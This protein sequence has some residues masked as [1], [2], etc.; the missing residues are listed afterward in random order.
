MNSR[1]DCFGTSFQTGV[2]RRLRYTDREHERAPVLGQL[3]AEGAAVEAHL[4]VDGRRLSLDAAKDQLA[5]AVVVSR[6]REWLSYPP[7]NDVIS[8]GE[9]EPFGDR[10]DLVEATRGLF[11]K[12]ACR[13]A[14]GEPRR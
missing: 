8:V 11:L 13:Y 1:L 9:T 14:L 7:L 10:H 5:R 4:V 12:A 3:V 2:R 6:E